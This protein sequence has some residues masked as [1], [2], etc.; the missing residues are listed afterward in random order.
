MLDRE[1]LTQPTS[2]PDESSCCSNL[3]LETP[4]FLASLTR[5]LRL[6]LAD[7]RFGKAVLAAFASASASAIPVAAQQTLEELV[8]TATK[9]EESQQDVP[10]AITALEN[11]DL[12]ALKIETLSDYM[13]YLPNVVSQGTG[14]GQN[15]LFIR[16]AA[17]SQT[18]ITLSSVQGLQP[19]V[20]LYVDEQPVALQGRNLDVYT[21]DV[22]RVEVL[23]GPQGTLFGASSQSGTV[24]IITEKPSFE[25]M[26]GGF[27]TSI[28]NTSGGEMSNSVEGHFNLPVNDKLAVRVAA[29]NDRQGGWIDH[30]LND[31]DNG[32]WNG[33][34]VV[35]D[36][37]SGG[38]LPDPEN[39][40]L[41]IPRNDQL[42][43]DDFNDATYT[44][45]RVS[46][47]YLFNDDWS[48]LLQ[49]TQQSLDTEGVWFYDPNLEGTSSVNRFAP[50]ENED[51]FGLS[52]WTL[53][54][55]IGQLDV[56]YTG[57]Y[58]DRDVASTIDY[59]FYTNGGL[60]AAYYVFYP[61]DGTYSQGFDP[62]K[63][64]KEDSENTRLTHEI[65]VNS[66]PAE[67]GRFIAGLFY[68]EQ[69]L[70]SVGK[71]KIASTDSPHFSNLARTLVAP[72]GTE[73]LN[74]DGGPFAPEFSF[75][76]DVT[77]TTEQIATFGQIEYDVTEKLT[78]AIGARWYSIDDAYKGST[79]TVNVTERLR[80]FGIGT[81]SALQ[82][83]FG[84][85]QGTTVFNAIQ[86]GQLDVSELSDN[87]I[88]NAE[89]VILRASLDYRVNPNILLFST[90]AQ[91]F[92]PP[93]TNRVGGGLA[94]NQTGAFQ[95]FRIPVSSETDDLDNYEIGVKGDFLDRTLRLNI[96]A[97]FSEIS[98]LQTSRFDP[99]NINFLWFADNVGDA[100]I[101]G[102]D[103]DFIW[104]V[105]DNLQLAGAFT[106]LDSEITRL[107]PEL[108]GISA[109]VG[110]ELP[111]SPSFSGNVRARYEFN[112]P[113][114]GGIQGL[115][116]LRGGVSYRGDSVSGLKMDAY[117]V[118]DTMRRV[119]Q[120]AGSGLPIQREA[121]NFAGAAP[122]T[123]LIGVNGV[124]GGRYIQ[125]A[126][127]L[128][129]AGVG[130]ETRNWTAEL[131]VDNLFDEDAA[132]YIDT[133]Q[134]TPHVVTNRPRT[135]GFRFSYQFE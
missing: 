8:V 22:E 70:A 94:N 57:G 108:Q 97:F 86:S 49:H 25:G 104:N 16:G 51:D 43:E 122:G 71:F 54:G 99:T 113:E 79:T 39:Q 61:G 11:A 4:S 46:A 119:Y 12:R 83:F 112:V 20:A 26:S 31:P 73:G 18:I 50:D 60:F 45:A 133:Q 128:V 116:F 56:I 38:P 27:S 118:E 98:N 58:L 100:E 90:F 114:I 64:Y 77:R 131:F 123:E 19:S 40:T 107:N 117:V 127:F 91:G 15:E 36:R 30:I 66:D 17:T 55:R 13:E 81:E 103:G 88:L 121:A 6:G 126:Y 68:D 82:D 28:S 5:R 75:V 37:I 2:S 14:P 33:S 53:E 76:N 65:R 72:P 7:T 35:V 47:A 23:P 41:P 92:R 132:Q 105:T 74:T 32:G 1:S 84:P 109:P 63:F 34:A 21:T 80:A 93:V 129:N 106:F 42:V 48:L 59:T 29:Y 52:T 101:L 10:V 111:F 44:G 85:A 89:D 110:S 9:R 134:F 130:I 69:E 3:D 87:G 78:A 24:R 102:V 120:V 125:E 62:S 124:P 115:G 135:V 67:K 95:G 96:T